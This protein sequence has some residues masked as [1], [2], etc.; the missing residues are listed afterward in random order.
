LVP[1][2][3]GTRLH[4]DNVGLYDALFVMQDVET[5]TLWNH[6]TG[7]A[8]YGPHVGRTLG[9]VGN[10]LQ[11][12]VEQALAMN[13][14]TEIAISDRVYFAGGK[15]LGTATGLGPGAGSDAARSMPPP[16]E[17]RRTEGQPRINADAE[18]LDQFV[19][20]LGNEDLRRPRMDVGLG[21][22]SGSLRRYYPMDSIRERDGAFFDEFDGRNLL[23]F[24]DPVTFTP[25]ALFVDAAHARV[26]AKEV[27][28]DDGSVF[29]SGVL[30]GR[31]EIAQSPNRPQQLFTRWY[32]FA[33]TFPGSEVFGQ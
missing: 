13:P 27:R 2:I 15:R 9:P 16:R 26:E 19:P 10:L 24:I 12:N 23:V 4:L 31:D 11:I 17:P 1:S 7:E 5:K 20:T 6:I 3:D 30:Y 33:L 14:A 8:L 28:F 21:V 32:G 22:W 25:T 18:L 29:R